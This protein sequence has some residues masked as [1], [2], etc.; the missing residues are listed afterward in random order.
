MKKIIYIYTN[1]VCLWI[2][3]IYRI[4]RDL[5][6]TPGNV[7]ERGIGRRTGNIIS[8]TIQ[9]LIFIF[10]AAVKSCLDLWTF[11]IPREVRFSAGSCAVVFMGILARWNLF[12]VIFLFVFTLTSQPLSTAQIK[13]RR[14]TFFY[15]DSTAGNLEQLE[16]IKSIS[17]L[18]F[19]IMLCHE[20]PNWLNESNPVIAK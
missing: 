2:L 17:R 1:D 8:I 5:G 12:H 14:T 13:A 7:C 20:Y 19:V 4:L 10:V 15:L 18:A 11:L 3:S 16:I 6:Q 9:L